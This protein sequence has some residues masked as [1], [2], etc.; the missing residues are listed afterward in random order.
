M[1]KLLSTIGLVAVFAALALAEN[2][3]GRLIDASCT[4]QQ[5]GQNACQPTSTTTTFAI[6]SAGHVYKLDDSGNMKAA[7]ALKNR[8]DRAAD[9]NSPG[10][11][12]VAVKISGTK[13]GDTIK[14]E[15]LE[16]Q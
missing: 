8:A 13:D 16:V 10:G 12:V 9:P 7:E 5:K 4:N 6:A 3:S 15:T 2:W 14:V 1:R 11:N